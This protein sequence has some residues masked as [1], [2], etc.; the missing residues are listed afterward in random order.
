MKTKDKYYTQNLFF[1]NYFCII[2]KYRLAFVAIS[3][4]AVTSLKNIAIWSKKGFMLGIKIIP[5][6]HR[7]ES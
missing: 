1:G 7:I 5:C 4:N 6:T 3:K 2:E